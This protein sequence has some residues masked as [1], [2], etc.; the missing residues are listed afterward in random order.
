MPICQ[1][2]SGAIYP[3]LKRLVDTA[4]EFIFF[5]TYSLS[6]DRSILSKIIKKK[7]E[8]QNLLAACLLP[9]PTDFILWDFSIRNR[10]LQAYG[11]TSL[12]QIEFA[13]IMAVNPQPAYS[14][15]DSIL[16]QRGPNSFQRS[17]LAHLEKIAELYQNQVITFL[18][19][20][21]HA[22]F[23]ASES[24]VYEGSGNLTY[25]GL[26]VN[27]EVYNFY[28]RTAAGGRVYQY[29][30]SS[31]VDFLRSY[32]TDFVN[33]KSGQHYLSNASQ[34]GAQVEQI[35]TQFN[36]RF[37]PRVTQEKIDVL[38]EAREQLLVS[39]SE[40]W[41]LPGHKLLLKLDFSLSQAS[42]IAQTVVSKL[43]GLLDKEIEKNKASEIMKDLETVYYAIKGVATILRELKAKMY[44]NESWYEI[45]HL[46]RDLTDA[47][48]F[49]EYLA[50]FE[51]GLSPEE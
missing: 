30:I 32:L 44:E 46:Q 27:V 48:K 47:N 12:N 8:N 39:R 28:P 38:T 23:V 43:W 26:R 7:Q 42:F 40:L 50:K 41:Q 24:D 29:A 15:L 36:V 17:L 6:V 35:A 22:K 2:L 25:F 10:I 20:N 49:K 11:L 37:N 14:V 33:W 34:L 3:R 51:K 9:P 4:N 5:G 16:T 1:R 31:Y 18:E 21:M 19:P 13:R 45:E